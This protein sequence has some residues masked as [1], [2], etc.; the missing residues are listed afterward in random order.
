MSAGIEVPF[1]PEKVLSEVLVTPVVVTAPDVIVPS[2]VMFP[3]LSATANLL[4]A[5]PI[6]LVTLRDPVV[7]VPVTLALLS[8]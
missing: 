1:P 5:A 8:T 2:V 7:V 4:P 6:P 3:V